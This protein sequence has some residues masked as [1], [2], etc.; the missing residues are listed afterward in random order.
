MNVKSSDG[1]EQGFVLVAVLIVLLILSVL[2]AAFIKQ[3]LTD[4]RLAQA[5]RTMELLLITADKALQSLTTPKA[6]AM[7]AS[8]RGV[9]GKLIDIHQNNVD[10]TSVAMLCY[11][12]T[13][14]EQN[15]QAVR[16]SFNQSSKGWCDL[17]A[18]NAVQMWIMVQNEPIQGDF[19]HIRTGRSADM[20]NEQ[21]AYGVNLRISAY[22]LAVQINGKLAHQAVSS[23]MSVSPKQ[24]VECLT[25][26]GV[27]YQMA[28]QEYG[29]E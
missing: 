21:F 3:S 28:V 5:S 27:F 15:F 29:Y 10:D 23:C 19:R 4:A 6:L 1:M 25:K 18:A 8:E 26:A 13:L 14:G 17:S 11:T 20:A 22:A 12:P 2:A 16:A 7:A 24:S 9:I